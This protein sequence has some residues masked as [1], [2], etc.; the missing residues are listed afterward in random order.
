MGYL[1]KNWLSKLFLPDKVSPH[2]R[3][4]GRYTNLKDEEAAQELLEYRHMCINAELMPFVIVGGICLALG[5]ADKLGVIDVR[6]VLDS[7]KNKNPTTIESTQTAPHP[8][9]TIE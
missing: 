8:A 2:D 9:P 6:E 1:R 4:R 7:L 3:N 5:A